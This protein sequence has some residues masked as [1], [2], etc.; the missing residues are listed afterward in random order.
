VGTL[1]LM[2]SIVRSG[3]P[4]IGKA[5]ELPLPPHL[6]GNGGVVPASSLTSQPRAWSSPI[7]MD[8]KKTSLFRWIYMGPCLV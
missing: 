1:D 8:E 5:L 7:R 2:I 4:G 6:M 3:V